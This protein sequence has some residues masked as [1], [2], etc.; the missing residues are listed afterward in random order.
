MARRVIHR[1][2]DATPA[3]AAAADPK[4]PCVAATEVEAS[5]KPASLDAG[6]DEASVGSLSAAPP[7]SGASIPGRRAPFPTGLCRRS[8]GRGR[9]RDEGSANVSKASACGWRSHTAPLALAHRPPSAQDLVPCADGS[10]PRLARAGRRRRRHQLALTRNPRRGSR[11]QN[12]WSREGRSGSRQCER[13]GLWRASPSTSRASSR[14]NW[15][16]PR[17]RRRF[18]TRHGRRPR[19]SNGKGGSTPASPPSRAPL[20]ACDGTDAASSPSTA[21]RESGRAKSP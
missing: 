11:R 13:E 18:A 10:H 14:R 17:A 16:D 8:D 12:D 3:C 2:G 7:R 4:A 19:A 5:L 21:A 6:L 15:I 9:D 1:L 20:P